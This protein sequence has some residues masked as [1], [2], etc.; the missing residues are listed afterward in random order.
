VR[1]F[2]SLLLLTIFFSCNGNRGEIISEYIESKCSGISPDTCEIYFSKVFNTS[3]DTM[4]VF[5]EYTQVQG[6]ISIL[7]VKE[8]NN[9]NY[10]MPEGFLVEDSHRKIISISHG[11]IVYDIDVEWNYVF[12]GGIEIVKNGIFDGDSIAHFAEIYVSP[13]F[14]VTTIQSENDVSDKSYYFLGN[15]NKPK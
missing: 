6:L 1:K 13:V 3:F 7:G 15:N 14:S 5:N 4:Y 12:S 2:S 10:F 11:E 9:T 8:Y